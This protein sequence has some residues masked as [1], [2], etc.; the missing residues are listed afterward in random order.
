MRTIT[1]QDKHNESK[2]WELSTSNRININKIKVVQRVD[3][4]ITGSTVY[5]LS[6]IESILDCK[7]T[8]PAPR[9]HHGPK[10]EYAV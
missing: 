4:R 2:T 3:G 5:P 9:A 8:F 10:N 6:F 7:I 1:I